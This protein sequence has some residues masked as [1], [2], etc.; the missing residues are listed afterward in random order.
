MVR[1]RSASNL[2]KIFIDLCTSPQ[3]RSKQNCNP[4]CNPALPRLKAIRS[5]SCS[6]INE[7]NRQEGKVSTE[8]DSSL[9]STQTTS[10]SLIPME[11]TG[12]DMKQIDYSTDES[13]SLFGCATIND[14]QRDQSLSK[15]ESS[16]IDQ[17]SSLPVESTSSKTIS[18]IWRKQDFTLR[19]RNRLKAR[20]HL[21]KHFLNE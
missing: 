6:D 10:T 21:R 3:L 18:P 12:F 13:L 11:S 5:N 2:N 19:L 1:S 15:Q 7:T 14:L 8:N 16:M 4:H 20:E 17:Y 9:K